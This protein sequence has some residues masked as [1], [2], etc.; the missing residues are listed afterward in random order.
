MNGPA[1]RG[2]RLHNDFGQGF[3]CSP[4]YQ[5]ACEW[6]CTAREAAYVNHYNFEPSRP[7][8][9]CNLAGP[10][11]HVLNWLAILLK[12]RTFDTPHRLPA[13]IKAY[14]LSEFLPDL[15][16]FDVIR[17]YRADDSCFSLASAFLN[18]SVTLGQLSEALKLGKL[19]E[20]VFL[21]S[22][23]AF[24][25]LVFLTAEK[26]DREYYLP[27]RIRRDSQARAAFRQMK[28][29][30][31]EGILAVDIYRGKWRN[32]DARIR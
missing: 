23:A 22:D 21:Q 19:G 18:G 29:S 20:Q 15:S 9:V 2:G 13:D 16:G 31:A 11:Y 28:D 27:R 30:G 25:A 24:E 10:D 5:L 8:T 7:L 17:G 6:A 3:Y 1:G 32:D 4:D 12:N 14:I 26:V